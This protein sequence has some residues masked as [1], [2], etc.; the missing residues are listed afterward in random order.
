MR[1]HLVFTLLLAL[2]VGPVLAQPA[3]AQLVDVNSASADTLATLP[4]IGDVRSKAIVAG[5]PYT[6]KADLVK[7]KV[8]SQGVLDGIDAK[9]AL[10]NI[11]T[12]SAKDLTATLPG[13]G[14]VRSAAI[15]KA[16]PYAKPEDLVTKKV[17]TQPQFDTIKALITTK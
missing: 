13:I 8:V 10:A 4:G 6:E 11:N 7:K 12:S 15:V 2:L 3:F 1:L 5:R 17:L 9:I 14:D 16:R